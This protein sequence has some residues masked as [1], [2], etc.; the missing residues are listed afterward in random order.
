[1]ALKEWLFDG[2][3]SY[4]DPL[5][6]V[7]ITIG[8]EDSGKS[9]LMLNKMKMALERLPGEKIING[10]LY[11]SPLAKQYQGSWVVGKQIIAQYEKKYPGG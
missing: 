2:A 7:D 11:P 5:S 8:A 3:T 10:R 6:A 4:D 1:M 9:G